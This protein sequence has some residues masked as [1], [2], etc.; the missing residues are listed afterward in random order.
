MHDSFP[1]ILQ[2]PYIL[3]PKGWQDSGVTATLPSLTHGLHNYRWYLAEADC[4]DDNRPAAGQPSDALEAGWL[5][6]RSA[7]RVRQKA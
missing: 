2:N 1:D 4:N 3:N 7:S 5:A 6:W